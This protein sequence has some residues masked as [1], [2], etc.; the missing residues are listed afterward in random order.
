MIYVSKD[1]SS[2]FY[3]NF[4]CCY[5]SFE[6]MFKMGLV[7][8][9]NR[10]NLRMIQIIRQKNPTQYVI[11]RSPYSRLVS[12]YNDKFLQCFDGTVNK[13][14]QTCQQLM[15]RFVDQNKIKNLQFTF[16]EFIN[17]LKRGYMEQH[18]HQQSNILASLVIKKP[19]IVLK[20]DD[21]SFND[22][23]KNLLKCEMPKDNTTTYIKNKMT[24][25]QIT[26][27]DKD[28]IHKFYEKDFVIFK[29]D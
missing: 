8:R 25:D 6:L 5:S 26:P 14:S 23:M 1:F 24:V 28:F 13:Q 3:V 16:S 7:Y 9:F 10:N 2:I 29:Y 21:P 19:Y 12:F 15:F 11:V 27:E 20:M 4:K 22:T 17:T 18:I